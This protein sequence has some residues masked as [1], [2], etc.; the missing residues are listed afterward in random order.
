MMQ[1]SKV[2]VQFLPEG[3]SWLSDKKQKMAF[4][5]IG[6]DGKSLIIHGEIVDSKEI[7]IVEFQSNVKGMGSFVFTPQ[8]G[9]KY[10]ARIETANGSF[11]KTLPLSTN[12]GTTLQVNNNL[13]SDSIHITVHS[14]LRDQELT[15]VGLANEQLYFMT[16]IMANKQVSNFVLPK[17]MFPIG[18]SQIT[19]VNKNEQVLNERSFFVNK[20]GQFN[21]QTTNTL[22]NANL[23][24]SI[25]EPSYYFNMPSEQKFNDLDILMLMQG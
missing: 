11:S 16:Q 7:K 15:L 10:I 17:S 14:D 1:L 19:L 9:E 20:S 13:N 3:G 22:S 6:V 24:G 21:V 25:E 23:R 12:K 4:K 2:T 8:A 18:V 5:A